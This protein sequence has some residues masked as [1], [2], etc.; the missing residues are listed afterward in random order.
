MLD[1]ESWPFL[2][3]LAWGVTAGLD[4]QTMTNDMFAYQDL[5]DAGELL[6]PRAYSTGPGIFSDNDFKT[7][8]Q[9]LAILRRYRDQYRTRN[10]KAYLTGNRKQRQLVAQAAHELEMMPTTEGGLDMEL[11]LT[12]ALD[13]FTGNEH[14]LPVVQES[15]RGRH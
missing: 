13:G 3:N 15:P 14:S 1:P 11:D 6:G 8:E 4:V 9:A 7:K 12:H 2:A 10:L 5:I